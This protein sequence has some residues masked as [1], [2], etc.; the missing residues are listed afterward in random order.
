MLTLIMLF[1]MAILFLLAAG[2][3]FIFTLA[4]ITRQYHREG[5][6]LRDS[7]SQAWEFLSCSPQT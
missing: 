6:S 3:L 2:A 5:M 4:A 1:A 7:I